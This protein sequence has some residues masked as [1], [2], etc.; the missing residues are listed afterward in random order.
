M[1][2]IDLLFYSHLDHLDL[3]W[4]LHLYAFVYLVA[5]SCLLL[6]GRE[7]QDLEEMS[8]EP[9]ELLL[10]AQLYTIS[11]RC[12]SLQV[13]TLGR[14]HKTSHSTRFRSTK[15]EDGWAKL[16]YTK[17]RDATSISQ[18]PLKGSKRVDAK[19]Q[20]WAW[21]SPDHVSEFETSR[22]MCCGSSQPLIKAV[23]HQLGVMGSQRMPM[24]EEW[25]ATNQEQHE[26]NC[27]GEGIWCFLPCRLVWTAEARPSR[28]H[29]GD[30]CLVKSK[31]F[32]IAC[33]TGVDVSLF[34]YFCFL[35]LLQTPSFGM[36]ILSEGCIWKEE[37]RRYAETHLVL[38]NTGWCCLG[39]FRNM[40]E[41]SGSS[42]LGC[43]ELCSH[44]SLF[45]WTG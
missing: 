24:V 44:H 14:R 25:F 41:R 17:L 19:P 30:L 39:G 10:S 40:R 22:Q 7:V 12:S 37:F 42:T 16:N 23:F 15:M 36:M 9:A 28:T 31:W 2:Y 45:D 13:R 4:L 6:H 29:C 27:M 18:I 43:S 5:A 1:S 26:T 3:F 8:W 35:P 38:T 33:S 21:V 20:V 32:R 34:F 11:R